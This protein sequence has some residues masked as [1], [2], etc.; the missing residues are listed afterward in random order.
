LFSSSKLEK[1]NPINLL[2]EFICL[3]KEG[4][5]EDSFATIS[6]KPDTF[7]I[8]FSLKSN[9]YENRRPYKYMGMIVLQLGL[10]VYN[11]SNKNNNSIGFRF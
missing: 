5:Y 11:L 1:G 6:R 9:D 4:D 2:N 8:G 10:D 3:Y 7:E